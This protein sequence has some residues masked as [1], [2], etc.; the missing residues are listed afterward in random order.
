MNFRD[1]YKS[2]ISAVTAAGFFVTDD[3]IEGGGDR[4]VC[5]SKRHEGGGYTG[6]SF[7]IAERHGRWFIGTWGDFV[8]HLPDVDTAAALAVT[9]LTTY[10]NTLFFD[11]DSELKQRFSLSIANDAFP[12]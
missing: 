5:V 10:P 2:L 7:W 6:N 1:E 4:V 8:Y 11:I 3:P 12:R 9:W